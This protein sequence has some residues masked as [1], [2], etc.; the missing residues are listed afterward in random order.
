MMKQ[1]PLLA[2][3]TGL[4]VGTAL[5]GLLT[6]CAVEPSNRST[7]YGGRPPVS[8]HA[9]MAFQDDYDYY[10]GYETYYSRNR[11]EFVYREGSTWVRRAE[12]RGVTIAML[13]AAP[14]V[15]LDFHDS[16]ER[17]HGTVV[18][19]YPRNWA[20]PRVVRDERDVRPVDNRNNPRYD[21]GSRQVTAV[22]Q[23]GYDYFPGYEV[24]YSHSR[25]DY[26]YRDGNAWVRRPEPKGV[27]RE[28][29]VAA[30]SVRLDFRDSPEQHH[31]T[32]VKSYPRNWKRPDTRPDDKEARQEDQRK[33]KDENQ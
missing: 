16:P 30:P 2:E 20:P 24:Y 19:T 10:P 17:H 13:F 1:M 7:A 33:D 31:A 18:R 29:L 25:R 8:V 11:R 21:A 15:R 27:K 4:A 12:P 14:T 9:T 5:L 32:V 3:K 28:V 23:E 22:G 6:G 26:I